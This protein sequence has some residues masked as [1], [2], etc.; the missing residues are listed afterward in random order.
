MSYKII[1]IKSASLG[2]EEEPELK[3]ASIARVSPPPQ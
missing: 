3:V 2:K 1:L